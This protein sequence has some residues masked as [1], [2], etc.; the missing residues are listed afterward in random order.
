MVRDEKTHQ[1]VFKIIYITIH[2]K[3]LHHV[4]PF[5]HFGFCLFPLKVFAHTQKKI[6]NNKDTNVR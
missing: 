6:V 2:P 3:P 4:T 1:K 5:D